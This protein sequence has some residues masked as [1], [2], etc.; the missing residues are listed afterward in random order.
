MRSE[1]GRA[2]RRIPSSLSLIMGMREGVDCIRKK[3][4]VIGDND[5]DENGGAGN[6]FI[7]SSIMTI[8]KPV[9]I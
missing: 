2:F 7:M 5:C 6:N 8:K 1:S 9:K 3:P 4:S